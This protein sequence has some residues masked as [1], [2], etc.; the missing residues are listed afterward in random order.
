MCCRTRS[1]WSRY[2]W[3]DIIGI[4][5]PIVNWGRKYNIKQNLLVSFPRTLDACCC[6]V[7]PLVLVGVHMA[8]LGFQQ[9]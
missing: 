3:L 5:F 9:Q 8:G 2:S 6:N 7:L 1:E 4:F